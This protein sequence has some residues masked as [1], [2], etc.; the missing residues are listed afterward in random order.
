MRA[1]LATWLACSGGIAC[2]AGLDH[3]AL[4]SAEPYGVPGCDRADDRLAVDRELR[5]YSN[6]SVDLAATTRGLQQYYRRHGLRF[7]TTTPPARA[8]LSYALD[9]DGTEL[10]RALEAAFPGVDLAD[11]GAL[12]RDPELYDRIV[13]F[14]LNHM[15]RPLLEFA[16]QHSARGTWV[17]NLVLLPQLQRPGGLDLFPGARLAGLAVSPALVQ[18]LSTEDSPE[19]ALWRAADLPARFT[20]L[21]FLDEGSLL[22]ASGRAPALRGLIAAHEFG[23]TGGLVHTAV[24]GNLMTPGH[25]D[26]KDALTD[27]QLSI[28]ANSLGVTPSAQPLRVGRDPA[29]AASG[30]A[31]LVPAWRFV[32]LLRGH[33]SPSRALLQPLVN[34]R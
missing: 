1:L 20:P 13:T 14:T 22:E 27:E 30:L 31:A 3:G 19:A 26:C 10:T 15:L 16:R 25:D 23:H 21:I 2:G 4:F 12:M 6:G 9:T 33:Q 18:R 17:T 32:A 28:L 5:L 7:F 29:V 8:A 11:A 34:S 24:R